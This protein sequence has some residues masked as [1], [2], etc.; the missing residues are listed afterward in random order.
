VETWRRAAGGD[1]LAAT[2]RARALQAYLDATE[3]APAPQ[4]RRMRFT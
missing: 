1:D 4:P 2:A 3:A